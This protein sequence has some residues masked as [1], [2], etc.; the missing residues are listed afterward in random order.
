M[1]AMGWEARSILEAKCT[2]FKHNIVYLICDLVLASCDPANVLAMRRYAR[3]ALRS[4]QARA[5]VDL[6]NDAPE[7]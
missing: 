2:T 3:M 6:G 5:P 1:S 7:L 4:R